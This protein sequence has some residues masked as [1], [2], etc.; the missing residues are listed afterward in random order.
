MYREVLDIVYRQSLPILAFNFSLHEAHRR[1]PNEAG[2]VYGNVSILHLLRQ[3]LTPDIYHNFLHEV[4]IPQIQYPVP[5]LYMYL[6]MMCHMYM[7]GVNF[8]YGKYMNGYQ[9]TNGV[10]FSSKKYING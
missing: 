1:V 6:I 5:V 8:L 3:T 7:N 4:T 10:F 2:Q 9:Y